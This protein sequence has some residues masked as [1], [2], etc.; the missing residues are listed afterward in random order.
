MLLSIPTEIATAR[1]SSSNEPQAGLLCP[2]ISPWAI[3]GWS[4]RDR[5]R[6]SARLRSVPF[7]LPQRARK[8]TVFTGKEKYAALE[9]KLFKS[10]ND[11]NRKWILLPVGYPFA[12]ESQFLK[13][14]QTSERRK[15]CP[16]STCRRG[17]PRWNQTGFLC[18]PFVMLLKEPGV[19][20]TA[21]QRGIPAI[22]RVESTV[23]E[24]N[25]SPRTLRCKS[26]V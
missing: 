24:E 16:D 14:R 13:H 9:D 18:S 10:S 1:S 26:V 7:P 3:F 20:V 15:L 22:I 2:R 19:Q 21:L 25:K 5:R 11:W 23:R 17:L 6:R 4:L 12:Q 8:N